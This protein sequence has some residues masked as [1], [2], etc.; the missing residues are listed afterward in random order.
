MLQSG[1]SQI[2]TL[3][4]QI[5]SCELRLHTR[6]H[7]CEQIHTCTE[8]RRA[9]LS[10][11]IICIARLI[12]LTPEKIKLNENLREELKALNSQGWIR[13]I[14][15]DEVDYMDSTGEGSLRPPLLDS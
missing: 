5:E 13:R 6:T 7:V 14:V 4:S 2:T 12:Y 8:V 10:L 11:T 15:L 3:W 1:E 9:V